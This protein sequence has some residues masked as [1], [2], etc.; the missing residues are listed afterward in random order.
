MC[1]FEHVFLCSGPVVDFEQKNVFWVKFIN[2]VVLVVLL[3]NSF[4]ALLVNFH[5]IFYVVDKLYLL[6]VLTLL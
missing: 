6:I 2:W 3:K 4:K 5:N 1:D